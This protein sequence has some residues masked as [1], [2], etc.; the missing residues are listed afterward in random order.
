MQ[1]FKL[2]KCAVVVPPKSC[3]SYLGFL[4]GRPKFNLDFYLLGWTLHGSSKGT[5]QKHVTFQRY[6]LLRQG[7]TSIMPKSLN[8]K[9]KFSMN[10]RVCVTGSSLLRAKRVAFTFALRLQSFFEYAAPGG[11]LCI[12]GCE[13]ALEGSSSAARPCRIES[14]CCLC[15]TDFEYSIIWASEREH[16][17]FRAR[18]LSYP[19][20]S[21]SLGVLA[22]FVVLFDF[23]LF[24]T[25]TACPF[26]IFYFLWWSTWSVCSYWVL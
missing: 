24:I 19:S 5:D 13:F 1:S 22:Y 25:S 26:T 14:T 4:L 8:C 17:Q 7:D 15:F 11:T 6:T 20:L 12:Q 18:T 10:I 3:F 2:L 16:F 23:L 21:S 9:P